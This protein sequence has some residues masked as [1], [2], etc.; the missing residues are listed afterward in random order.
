MDSELK[1]FR[2]G[3][4][5]RLSGTVEQKIS[6]IGFVPE[7]LVRFAAGWVPPKS[8]DV[9]TFDIPDDLNEAING[10][11]DYAFYARESIWADMLAGTDFRNIGYWDEN[12]ETLDQAGRNLQDQL[13]A[14]LPEKKGRILDVACGMGAST[15]RLL[16]DYSP[17]NVWAIN[18]SAKQ[19]ETTSQNAPGCNAIVMS[20]TEMTFEDNFFDAIECIEAAFHFETRRK[21]LEDSLRILKP[22]G[23]LVISDVLMASAARLEQYPVFPSPENHI[24]T[25][26]EYKSLLEETGFV[27]VTI[28]DARDKIWEPHFM[29]TTNRIQR[30]FLERKYNIVE[31]MDMIWTYYELDVIT[32]PC[33]I[34]GASKPG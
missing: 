16:N 3:L 30:G 26:E 12:T 18:I 8:A 25:I 4:I 23:R 29:A 28:D 32:G 33:L 17:E 10:H 13:L 7:E 9:E 14:L 20:A 24:G 22:G 27:D 1:D 6:S 19:I 15:K 21:F 2:Q 31:V 11:Y 5:D 34:L